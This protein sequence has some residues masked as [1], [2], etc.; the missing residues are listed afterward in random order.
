M[1]NN[2]WEVVAV[3]HK[4]VPRTN[5]NGEIL[6]VNGR[7]M[8]DERFSREPDKVHWIANEGVRCS[9]IV[10]G[11]EAATFST[12]EQSALRDKILDLWGQAYA[13]RIGFK[14]GWAG[15]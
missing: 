1:F 9:R 10:A 11:F 7:T 12:S 3:H 2:R 4:A 5:K 15:V 8:S 13:R 6:D 14:Y